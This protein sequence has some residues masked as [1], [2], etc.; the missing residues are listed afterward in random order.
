L[1]SVYISRIKDT[2]KKYKVKNII[3]FK[4]SKVS[5]QE[6]FKKSLNNQFIPYIIIALLVIFFN[7]IAICGI[8]VLLADDIRLWFKEINKL[9]SYRR[10]LLAPFFNQFFT[11]MILISPALARSF[12][13]VFFMVPLSWTFYYLLNK[14]F[15]LPR[16][17]ALVCAVIPNIL[18]G[19]DL[20]PAYIAGSHT[21]RGLL[22]AIISLIL[23][24]K[25]LKSS[26]DN[27]L[28]YYYLILSI[29]MFFI[30]SHSMAEHI[31][32]LF[33]P[34]AIAIW[35]YS[36]N[37]KRKLFILF[38]FVAMVVFKIYQALSHPWGNINKPQNLSPEQIINRFKGAFGNK[39]LPIKFNS[40][41][42][43]EYWLLI[44]CVFIFV[45]VLSFILNINRPG[46]ISNINHTR[47]NNSLPGKRKVI[48]L[49]TFFIIW[50]ISTSFVFIFFSKLCISR[51]FYIAA[52]GVNTLLVLS[53]YSICNRFFSGIRKL[54]IPALVFLILWSGFSRHLNLKKY[55]NYHNNIKNVILSHISQINFLENSQ[56]VIVG[57]FKKKGR[58]EGYANSW[59]MSTGYLS[60]ITQRRD[61][62][63][64]LGEEF[65]YYNPFVDVQRNGWKNDMTGLSLEKPLFLFKRV[66][67]K[68]ELIQLEYFLQWKDKT[69]NADWIL[70]KTDKNSGKIKIIKHGEGFDQYNNAVKKIGL[71]QS[72]VLWGGKPIKKTA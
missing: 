11:K 72:N 39:L 52:F 29:L 66:P 70:Y 35:F 31:V 56:I 41:F 20:I 54:Y 7:L 16:S 18:P 2:C 28:K 10:F 9:N 14:I 8:D 24:L 17:I 43:N 37:L 69:K 19:Q 59:A 30:A 68:N 26:T 32:F 23:A 6:I 49:Y 1:A 38:F 21:T 67:Q 42:M 4:I 57:F 53:I 44:I 62:S 3:I 50:S 51:Y 25:Y 36:N 27:N 33:P 22:F 45:I 71:E 65:F 15:Y 46:L 63:G 60:F 13:L 12:I 48:N 55:Y 5:M 47:K 40:T 64:L 58:K 34:F 61:I